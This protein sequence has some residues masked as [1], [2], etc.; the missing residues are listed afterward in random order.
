MRGLYQRAAAIFGILIVFTSSSCSFFTIP[1]LKGARKT[2][3]LSI[4]TRGEAVPRGLIDEY[5]FMSNYTGSNLLFTNDTLQQA[6]ARDVVAGE[7][8]AGKVEFFVGSGVGREV[9]GMNWERLVNKGADQVLESGADKVLNGSEQLELLRQCRSAFDPVTGTKEA[10]NSIMAQFDD[11]NNWVDVVKAY[12]NAVDIC[13]YEGHKAGIACP[14]SYNFFL[15]EFFE[16]CHKKE[17]CPTKVSRTIA[18]A[19]VA[20]LKQGRDRTYAVYTTNYNRAINFA[21]L[22]L[23]VVIEEVYPIRWKANE[24]TRDST[25]YGDDVELMRSV[26]TPS[27]PQIGRVVVFHLHGI[28]KE[29]AEFSEPLKPGPSPRSIWAHQKHYSLGKAASLFHEGIPAS[30]VKPLAPLHTKNI[31]LDIE[32]RSTPVDAS[33]IAEEL[34]AATAEGIVI[35]DAQYNC[36]EHVQCLKGTFQVALQDIDR[37]ILMVGSSMGDTFFEKFLYSEQ[38]SVGLTRDEVEEPVIY[39]KGISV[40]IQPGRKAPKKFLDGDSNTASDVDTRIKSHL[41]F[42][43]G[44]DANGE[45][46]YDAP[47]AFVERCTHGI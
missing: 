20:Q 37:T 23:G 35:T 12:A 7:L 33:S 24:H 8:R 38:F 2:S 18:E 45:T 47:R 27:M 46:D 34:Y 44:L 11:M 3:P 13:L 9:T 40:Q 21:L 4:S 22:E 41:L 31:M 32:H 29:A 16:Q 14:Q 30:W 39:N 5:R 1:T 17:S 25:T 26:L 6:F 15:A 43:L 36:K 10:Q 42:V 19:I 28:A